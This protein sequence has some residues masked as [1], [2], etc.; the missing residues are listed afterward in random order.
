MLALVKLRFCMNNLWAAC[1]N[2]VSHWPHI[3]VYPMLLY[4]K[5]MVY[6][7]IRSYHYLGTHVLRQL[8]L[9]NCRSAFC[10]M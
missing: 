3:L 7:V 2:L 4:L 10:L 8:L 9:V 5:K 6:M 1:E